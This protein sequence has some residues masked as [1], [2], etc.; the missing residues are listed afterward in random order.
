M[1]IIAGVLWNLILN[2]LQIPLTL[3]VLYLIVHQY[4]RARAVN[5]QYAQLG[6]QMAELLRLVAE[7]SK[8]QLVYLERGPVLTITAAPSVDL[9]PA[10]PPP[11]PEK[12]AED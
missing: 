12:A 7:V 11:A 9:T 3:G 8:R 2:G 5:R 6:E 4:R 1:S 10:P